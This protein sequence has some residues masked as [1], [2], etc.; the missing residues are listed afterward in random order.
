MVFLLH[1]KDRSI[2]VWEAFSAFLAAVQ[3]GLPVLHHSAYT[4]RIYV[5]I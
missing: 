3:Q 1:R 5:V 2:L 4:Q